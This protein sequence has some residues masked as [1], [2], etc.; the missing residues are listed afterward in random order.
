MIPKKREGT[1]ITFPKVKTKNKQNELTYVCSF[2]FQS[3]DFVHLP[4]F[5]KKKKGMNVNLRF[6][7]V[8][9]PKI[10]ETNLLLFVRLG[11]SSSASSVRLIFLKKERWKC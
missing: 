4:D 6:P 9:K 7:K 8:K 1:L 2:R 5:P 10:N 3:H 11:S